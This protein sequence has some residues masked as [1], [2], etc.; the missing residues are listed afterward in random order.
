MSIIFLAELKDESEGSLIIPIS[1]PKFN[2]P[3]LR[4]GSRCGH[5]YLHARASNLSG[6]RTTVRASPKMIGM[7]RRQSQPAEI[8]RSMAKWCCAEAE[9]I[10]GRWCVV[11]IRIVGR[12]RGGKLLDEVADSG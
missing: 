11:R 5:R 7:K 12:V 4:G 8:T 9:G 1:E 3:H 6:T 10:G 2:H